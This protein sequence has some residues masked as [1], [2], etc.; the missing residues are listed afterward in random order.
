MRSK[1]AFPIVG[2]IAAAAAVVV[3]V[4]IG[5]GRH[6]HGHAPAATTA[7]S[8]AGADGSHASSSAPR[9]DPREQ[10]KATIRGTV[11]EKGGPPLAGAQVCAHWWGHDVGD[12]VGRDP[13]CALTAADGRYQLTGVLP[14]HE[15]IDASAAGHVPAHYREP[16]D[17]G[18][19]LT[20]APGQT[21]EGVD[22]ELAPGGAEVHGVVGDVNGGPIADAI[23][24]VRSDWSA[25]GRGSAVAR[26]GADGTFT[27]WSAPGN[28]EVQASAAGYVDGNREA[29][30]PA[31]A[32]ELLLTPESVLEGTVVK[33]GTQTPVAGVLVSASRGD[34]RAD[35][36]AEESSRTGADGRFR[37]TRLEPGRYKP[38]A[39]GRGVR[40]QP[41]E[42]VLLGLDRKSVV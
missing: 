9:P 3:W 18:E 2:L 19:G 17:K 34:P 24:T 20:L 6:R 29:I 23:V 15:E 41:A 5:R 40:G 13:V 22:V 30:A 14:G 32:V 28:I 26:T 25:G 27:L 7:T 4:A 37:L 42:S 35:R 33:A 1:S 21:R 11:R 16:G 36:Y 12:D 38:I 31:H 8:A 39:V 10:P